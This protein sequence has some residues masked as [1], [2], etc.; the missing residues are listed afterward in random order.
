[1][2][3]SWMM[4][5]RCVGWRCA[6]L[7][8]HA[9]RWCRAGQAGGAVRNEFFWFRLCGTSN[10]CGSV[11]EGPHMVRSQVSKIGRDFRLRQRSRQ[12]ERPLLFLGGPCP[13]GPSSSLLYAAPPRPWRAVPSRPWKGRPA[14]VLGRLR[15]TAQPLRRRLLPARQ[16]LGPST[17]PIIPIP[18]LRP[19][20]DHSP[21]HPTGTRSRVPSG[22]RRGCSSGRTPRTL[23]RTSRS[24]GGYTPLR[25]FSTGTEVRR[26]PNSVPST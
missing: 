14:F 2:R 21:C 22:M 13:P 19:C 11:E 7:S 18:P 17:E 20:H 26:R 24:T 25:Q 6:S 3:G 8:R 9:E 15:P 4:L 12:R 1:M 16:V 23:G 10:S 5:G